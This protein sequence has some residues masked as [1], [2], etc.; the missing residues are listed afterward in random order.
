MSHIEHCS[1]NSQLFTFICVRA[2]LENVSTFFGFFND[3]RS[4]TSIVLSFFFFLRNL[5]Y[6]L[7][8]LALQLND[9]C[10]RTFLA[11]WTDSYF[12]SIYRSVYYKC[13]LSLASLYGCASNI[14]FN[15]KNTIIIETK[16]E[17]LKILNRFA[18]ASSSLT[19]ISA[20]TRNFMSVE[21]KKKA[22]PRLFLR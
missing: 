6:L 17:T 4:N 5:T 1:Y 7:N 18:Q 9:T 2:R 20:L 11:E 15:I 8:M 3:L 16:I 13:S 14:Y 12:I 21:N 19:F 10:L 22:F